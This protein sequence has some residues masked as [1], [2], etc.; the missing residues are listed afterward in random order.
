MKVYKGFEGK[1]LVAVY[2]ALARYY[3]THLLDTILRQLHSPAIIFS[4]F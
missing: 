1:T 2:E 4:V 3:L